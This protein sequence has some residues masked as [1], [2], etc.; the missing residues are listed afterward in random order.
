MINEMLLRLL[1][2]KPRQAVP[3]LCDLLSK[4]QLR[5]SSTSVQALNDFLR[6][7]E[8][9][10]RHK[11]VFV[12]GNES[13]D[14]DSMVSAIAYAFLE[15]QDHHLHTV[16]VINIPR[17]EF[18]FRAEALWLFE[19]L[20]MSHDCLTFIDEI[21]LARFCND[22][23]AELFLVDHNKLCPRQ[24]HLASMVCG[25]VDH[26]VDEHLYTNTCT[27]RRVIHPSGSAC[28]LVAEAFFEPSCGAT[29]PAA[30]A[31]MLLATILVD[32]MDLDP[33]K[34]KVTPR[35]VVAAEKLLGV[36]AGDDTTAQRAAR[37]AL[38]DTLQKEKYNTA[39]LS[40][41][42]SLRKD[43]K[44]YKFGPYPVGIASVLDNI[45]DLVAKDPA[46]FSSVCD[47]FCTQNQI[48]G[49]IIM[50]AYFV[51]REFRREI[52]VI[53]AGSDEAGSFYQKLVG[54]LEAQ[55]DLDLKPMNRKVWPATAVNGS[56]YSQ[57]N[58]AFSRKKLSPLLEKCFQ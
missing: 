14:L 28:T 34:L 13:A 32:T 52:V 1:E 12:M 45:H 16:P 21:D 29:L 46:N 15:Y 39:R 23:A 8:A 7:K 38:F 58:T 56:C 36:V 18:V 44:A 33:A 48:L 4:Q 43:Y 24:E 50:C 47:S 27:R 25:A 26:H 54:S 20:G 40:V 42:D 17:H 10:L 51:E 11:P 41:Q 5:A 9:H 49:L 55:A 53:Q 2:V 3:F 31:K 30:L 6:C 35:D 37:A 57:G 19:S 22:R